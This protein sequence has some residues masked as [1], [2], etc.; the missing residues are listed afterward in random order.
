M[1]PRRHTRLP[2]I[3]VDSAPHGRDA[4]SR[5]VYERGRMYEGPGAGSLSRRWDY[6][7]ERSAAKSR[8]WD[9]WRQQGLGRPKW[10]AKESAETEYWLLLLNEFLP[11][12]F[13]STRWFLPYRPKAPN[14]TA[15]TP[16]PAT[17][18]TELCETIKEW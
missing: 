16:A 9:G 11:F 1:P 13:K 5:R 17:N 8:V 18:Q 12:Y 3:P 15:N 2:S 7:S 10:V 14:I 4:T 6:A